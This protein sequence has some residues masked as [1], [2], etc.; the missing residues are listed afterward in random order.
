MNYE[1]I[2]IGG[3][4][5]GL[6]VA[7]ELALADIKVCVIEQLKETTPYSKALTIHPRSLELLDMRGLKGRLLELGQPLP[8][9]HFA[10]L[11]TRLDFSALDSASNYTLYLE[12]EHTEQMLEDWARSLGVDI[13]R[14]QRALRIEQHDERAEV[15]VSGRDGE[16]LL[17][18]Q[19]VVGADGA[20]STAR[21]QAGIAFNGTDTT[22]TAILGDVALNEPPAGPVS[23]YNEKGIVMIVPM[24]PPLY[25]VVVVDAARTGVP[26]EEPV[27]LDELCSSLQRIVGTD[28]GITDAHWLSR[29]GNATRQAD[30]YREGRILLA[31][32]AAHIHFPAGGQGMNVGL[33]EAFNLGWKL[34]AQIKGKAPDWLLDSYHEERYPVN[35]AL[36][37]NTEVQTMLMESSPKVK[38]LRDLLSRMLQIPAANY[39]MAEQISAFHVRY[40]PDANMPEHPLNGCRLAD[41]QI[42]LSDGSIHRFYDYFHSGKFVLLHAVDEPSLQEACSGLDDQRVLVVQ[43]EV[44]STKA[45]WH[46]VH[47]AL[48]RPDGYVAWAVNRTEDNVHEII[49]K[50]LDHWGLKA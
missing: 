49:K 8:T 40:A 39:I 50:G 15:L 30:R 45:D 11:D 13:L 5:V 18:A 44:E 36:L 48:V 34:A 38:E 35:T 46:N 22:I 27:T 10:V 29:F 14:E 43:G 4:P 19:Y 32:D 1:V 42:K 47:A 16:S 25:R 23:S 24:T 6:T 26:K 31:G 20:G 21:K 3:G 37:R 28:Y 41:I 2:V 12:Q 17:T 7:A 33:Q 9:G